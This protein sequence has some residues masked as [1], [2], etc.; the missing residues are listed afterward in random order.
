MY[1]H[2]N[3]TNRV[4]GG[5]SNDYYLLT[6]NVSD[7]QMRLYRQD[8]TT[9]GVTTWSVIKTFAAGL[10]PGYIPMTAY[11]DNSGNLYVVFGIGNGGGADA[12]VWSVKYSDGS[13]TKQST[14]TA[15]YVANYQSRIII[16]NAAAVNFTDPGSFV[17]IATNTSP[18]D[19]SEG[20]PAILAFGTFSPGDLMVFKLGAPIYLV[21]GDLT[22]Y[23]VR[24][25]NGARP[26]QLGGVPVV[27]G[28]NGL[29]FRA[30]TDGIYETP[31][32]ST[33]TPL[34]KNLASNNFAQ[35]TVLGFQYHWLIDT[36]SGLVMD[37]D[38][39]CWFNVSAMS[40]DGY[41]FPL[42]RAG[43]LM[44]ADNANGS[45]PLTLTTTPLNETGGNRL[46]SYTIKTAPLRN[47]LGRQIEIRQ[48]Q[49][50]ARSFNGATSTI[51]VTVN[52]VTQTLACD[53]SG[54]GGLTFYFRARRE[55]LDVQIVV[56]S[57]AVGV[58]APL[59]E[60]VRIGSQ[61]GH[62]LRQAADVG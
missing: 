7:T 19:I 22:N 56:A 30:G 57:N 42:R 4:G 43:Q 55:E 62:Y 8:Q 46:E 31:D 6:Y 51:A 38:T 39:R 9:A 47:P 50:Y 44:I 3:I 10:D 17:N 5:Q 48:V 13:V 11:N 36:R 2:E 58:E 61:G 33:V 41:V 21:E 25:M 28:P 15:N 1:V 14:I 24:Q 37:Y 23:T 29:I 35:T 49:V 34:S 53:S 20:Q 59:L 26:M 18:V 54:R 12:G 40:G 27:R 16:N 52:G 45:G 32:G 60:A